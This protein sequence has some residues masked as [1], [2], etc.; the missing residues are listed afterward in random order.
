MNGQNGPFWNGIQKGNHCSLN[1]I[2]PSK[3][4][5]CFEFEV[6]LYIQTSLHVHQFTR[7]AVF[8]CSTLTRLHKLICAFSVQFLMSPVLK[9]QLKNQT[10]IQTVGL[11]TWLVQQLISPTIWTLV[12]KKPGFQMFLMFGYPVF[13]WS[14]HT[15]SRYVKL[16]L[17]LFMMVAILPNA[18]LFSC[19]HRY[20]ESPY[21]SSRT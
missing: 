12:T 8:Q 1:N 14:V 11:I 15:C 16:W 19:L 21:L 4:R 7:V 10:G 9:F 2:Q 3:I 13:R 6:S 5:M 18:A 20:R 17:C